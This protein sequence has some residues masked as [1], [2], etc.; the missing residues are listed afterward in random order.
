MNRSIYGKSVRGASHIRSGTP[1][2]D[3]HKYIHLTDEI[4]VIAVA[5]G[6][7]SEACPYSKSGSKI[8]VNVFCKA[9]SDLVANFSAEEDFF[10]TYLNREG[11]LRVAQTIDAEW[12]RRVWKA[13]VD[14][15][16]EKPLGEDGETDKEAVYKQY[17]TTLLGL[18]ITPRFVFAFQLGDGDIMYIDNMGAFPVI[19]GDKILGTETHS[20]CKKE[21]W[22]KAISLVRCRD[23]S[24]NLPYLYLVSTDGFANSHK[25][26]ADFQITCCEYYSLIKEYGFDTVASNLKEWLNETSALGCGDDVTVVMAYFN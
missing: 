16:R 8:A 17:G 22:K 13:H 1:C 14:N 4:T 26:V 7:G 23:V 11:E 25:S 15:K 19:D 12:K 18:L 2:Q 24:E 6:H 10:L 3:S 9:M 20:L 5:D 21:A